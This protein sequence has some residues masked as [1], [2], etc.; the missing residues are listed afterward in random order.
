VGAD[1]GFAYVE[2]ECDLLDGE[3]VAEILKDRVLAGGEIGGIA[4]YGVNLSSQPTLLMPLF[5]I[6]ARATSIEHFFKVA[7]FSA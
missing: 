4:R 3:A 2:S 6:R 5:M 7:N 1:R